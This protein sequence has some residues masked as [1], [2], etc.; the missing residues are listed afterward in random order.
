MSTKQSNNLQVPI[1]VGAIILKYRS[2]IAEA[3]AVIS[4]YEEDA[5]IISIG[6]HSGIQQV[7]EEAYE[8]LDKYQGLLATIQ[9]IQQMKQPVPEKTTE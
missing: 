1:E 7:L 6:E 9:R 5:R 4:R 8:K 3:S 2:K